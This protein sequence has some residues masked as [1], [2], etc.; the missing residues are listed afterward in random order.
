[1]CNLIRRGEV[2]EAVAQIV[3]RTGIGAVTARV[4]P[5]R[6]GQNFVDVP[7]TSTVVT[8]VH[9]WT[10]LPRASRWTPGRH[11]NLYTSV[12][13]ATPTPY[14]PPLTGGNVDLDHIAGRKLS[15]PTT[16]SSR[17]FQASLLRR[18]ALL[19]YSP[20]LFGSRF[21]LISAAMHGPSRRRDSSSTT[22]CS[23]SAAIAS[24]SSLIISSELFSL[25]TL[26]PTRIGGRVHLC[27]PV[28]SRSSTDSS[29]S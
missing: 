19:S 23:L 18:F 22:F 9:G 7:E 13:N 24:R 3:G 28:S 2:Y 29:G 14:S 25:R 16:Q 26:A 11:Q 10:P 20:T 5:I 4:L 15:A 21:R 1:G 6:S 27:S 17:C 12:K 8:N